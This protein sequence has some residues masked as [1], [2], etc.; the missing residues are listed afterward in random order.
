M[1]ELEFGETSSTFSQ[2]TQIIE[3]GKCEDINASST[4][5]LGDHLTMTQDVKCKQVD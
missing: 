4:G 3:K 1:T 5:A 2:F